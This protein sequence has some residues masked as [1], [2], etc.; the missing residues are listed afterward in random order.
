MK[1]EKQAVAPA[2]KAEYEPK[3]TKAQLLS[4]KRFEGR[5][6]AMTAVLSDGETYTVK[7][8]ETLYDNY[9]KGQ[10]N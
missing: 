5:K 1:E 8:A 6:D 7:E 4:A 2:K 9:M 10:V 3:F